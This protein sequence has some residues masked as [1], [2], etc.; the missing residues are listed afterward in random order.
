MLIDCLKSAPQAT[1]SDVSGTSAVGTAVDDSLTSSPHNVADVQKFL[2]DFIG[3]VS[4]WAIFEDGKAVVVYDA[5]A[6]ADKQGEITSVT[7]DFSDGSALS[8]VGLPADLHH[9]LFA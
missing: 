6:I 1:A 4:K 8:L 2:Q 3:S 9:S 5:V 7:F